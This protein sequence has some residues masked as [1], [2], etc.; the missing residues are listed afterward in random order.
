M[1]RLERLP[2]RIFLRERCSAHNLGHKRCRAKILRAEDTGH[3]A[4]PSR[5]PHQPAGSA[6]VGPLVSFAR[7]GLNWAPAFQS[8]LE[9]A[10]ACDV[11]VLWAC[12]SGVWYTCST[13]RINVPDAYSP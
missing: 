13:R 10:E 3:A 4:A 2:N 7:S 11:P 6:G 12:R 9:L 8:L 1:D 5:P